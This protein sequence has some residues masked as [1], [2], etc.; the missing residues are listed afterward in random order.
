MITFNEWVSA[1]YLSCKIEQTASNNPKRKVMVTVW[2]DENEEI[3]GSVYAYGETAQ[4]AKDAL[5]KAY[6]SLPEEGEEE[7]PNEFFM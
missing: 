1:W 5:V 2:D 4:E 7:T 6:G 3:G